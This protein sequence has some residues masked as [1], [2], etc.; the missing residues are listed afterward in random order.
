MVAHIELRLFASLKTY[1]PQGAERFPITSGESVEALI[2]RLGISPDD[3]KLIFINGI[4]A[5]ISST[6]W[7]GERVGVFPPVGGG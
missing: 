4:R 2:R 1:L 3:V 6:L 5:D 7:G